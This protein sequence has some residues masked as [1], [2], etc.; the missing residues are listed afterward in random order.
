MQ[1][2]I[3][4]HY[5]IIMAFDRIGRILFPDEWNGMESHAA[6]SFQNDEL[7]AQIEKLYSIGDRL[8][9][10]AESLRRM[11]AFSMSAEEA[12]TYFERRDEC[13]AEQK[14]VRLKLDRL[15]RPHEN[16]LKDA[17]AFARR[18]TVENRLANLFDKGELTL[19]MDSG[20]QVNWREFSGQKG[21]RISYQYSTIY[22]P[23]SARFRRKQA[24]FVQREKFDEW[25]RPFEFCPEKADLNELAEDWFLTQARERTNIPIRGELKEEYIR[26]FPKLSKR[27]FDRL[28]DQYAPNKWS[29]RG[30]KKGKRV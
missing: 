19:V 14:E 16:D 20:W 27:S 18:E 17:Q 26:E 9:Q 2:D 22:L 6:P 23:K 4:A 7:K 29:G 10:E 28:W 5:P 8:A 30:P 24:V 21:F 3:A 1:F 12:Q 15:V 25:A 13:S 11:D